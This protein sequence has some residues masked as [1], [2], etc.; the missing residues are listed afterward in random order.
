MIAGGGLSGL[1]TAFFVARAHPDAAILVLDGAERIGG[2][3][4]WS[5]FETDLS[6]PALAALEPFARHRWPSYDVAF[7]ARRRTIANAY[8]SGDS[9]ALRALIAPLIADG[10]ITVRTGARVVA[11]TPQSASLEHGERFEAGAVID[12]RGA[13]PGF[14]ELGFQKFVGEVVRTRSDHGVERPMVMDASVS[15][16][17]G[18]RFFYLLPYGPRE[19]LIED[20][21]YTD[22]PA[23]DE[24]AM[25]GAIKEYAEN[26]GIEIAEVLHIERGVLP[27][28]LDGD[29]EAGV[30]EE[31]GAAPRIGVGGGLF[32]AVT[33][34]SL[35]EAVRMAERIAGSPSLAPE[36]L[37]EL[38]YDQRRSHFAREAYYRLLNRILFRAAAPNQRYRVLQRF[39]GLDESLIARFYAG[40]SSFADKAR[41]LCGKPPVPLHR[42]IAN[43]A[44]GGRAFHAEAR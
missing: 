5:F 3:H 4:T 26:R 42:A 35:P 8:R 15:Q 29:V 13:R 28:T 34:Y 27:L 38:I 40:R 36:T 17:G 43:I 39:Y 44:P 12:A 31:A 7:P 11:T 6:R 19:V 24:S 10:R 1:L 18:Y 41:T 21:R 33:G 32:H 9:D 23:L 2:D 30:A 20:T 25:R 22:G 14:L 37:R 16:E